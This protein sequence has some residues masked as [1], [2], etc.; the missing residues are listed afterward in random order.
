MLDIVV[1][2]IHL[3][4]GLREKVVGF[5]G[6]YDVGLTRGHLGCSHF[7]VHLHALFAGLVGSHLLLLLFTHDFSLLHF[8][9][10]RHDLGG[11]L[12]PLKVG[13]SNDGGVCLGSLLSLG[14][15]FSQL[16]G[17]DDGE[18]SGLVL[19]TS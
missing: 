6:S 19:L 10:A 7:V 5:I 16:L 4:L 9:L 15:D 17:G 8:L 18:V 14:A 12:D 2:L 13:C 11:G 1:V 3:L